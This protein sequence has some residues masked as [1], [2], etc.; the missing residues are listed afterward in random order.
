[1][2]LPI[3]S[4]SQIKTWQECPSKWGYEYLAGKRSPPT[5]ATTLGTETHKKLEDYLRGGKPFATAGPAATLALSLLKLTPSPRHPGLKVEHP[6]QI[7]L[8]PGAAR[9]FMDVFIP[10]PQPA[11]LPKDYPFSHRVPVVLDHKT[12]SNVER[13]AKTVEDLKSDPQAI[14]YGLAA[15]AEMA[16]SA[17]RSGAKR[18]YVT[19]YE[20]V[21]LVWNYTQT[22]GATKVQSTRLRQSL[23][24]LQDGLRTLRPT[25]EA[26]GEVYA[27]VKRDEGH[28]TDVEGLSYSLGACSN[29]GG[30]PHRSYCHAHGGTDTA[31][32][33]KRIGATKVDPTIKAKLAALNAANAAK[34]AA[35][36]VPPP[37]TELTEAQ[38]K[39]LFK[40]LVSEEDARLL[41]K[42]TQPSLGGND[43]AAQAIFK[44]LTGAPNAS[45]GPSA[46]P[47]PA[48][49]LDTGIDT[50]VSPDLFGGSTSVIPP[51]ARPNVS[52]SDPV[53]PVPEPAKKKKASKTVITGPKANDP[54][55]QIALLNA[56]GAF[57][58]EGEL[59]AS[60]HLLSAVV[61]LRKVVT[62]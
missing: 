11:L 10:L 51:D 58:A 7:L 57:I 56:A 54:A 61:A 14:I 21:D 52:P 44:E 4:P 30:C 37:L 62:E 22:K 8:A 3:F 16:R 18:A 48:S 20:D 17:V 31:P 60:I 49:L 25:L 55:F 6:F 42:Y 35:P 33:L 38:T 43:V 1:M 15:R 19:D 12:T 28:L 2:S 24:T 50:G 39:D 36:P 59:E 23:A 40:E 41:A 53:S 9:G 47:K 34:R 5:G 32:Q 29:Y 13:Y 45:A 27:R 46:E 26:I